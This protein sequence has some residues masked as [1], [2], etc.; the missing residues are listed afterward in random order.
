MLV[1]KIIPFIQL[2]R[3]SNCGHPYLFHF[4]IS[5]LQNH[6]TTSPIVGDAKDE[7]LQSVGDAKDELSQSV[8]DYADRWPPGLSVCVAKAIQLLEESHE[9]MEEQGVG[10]HQLGNMKSR[11]KRMKM[12]LDLLRKA[13]TWWKGGFSGLV[14]R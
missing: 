2:R 3:C 6:G 4:H 13:K 8:E 14:K 9:A 12:K 7:L 1:G 10:Q 11:L 5:L